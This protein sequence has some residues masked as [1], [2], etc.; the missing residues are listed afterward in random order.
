VFRITYI[1]GLLL[2]FAQYVRI[3][4]DQEISGETR[5]FVESKVH[6]GLAS[7]SDLNSALWSP[8]LPPE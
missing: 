8:R 1:V 2:A 4:E 6:N 3:L 5:K 7:L